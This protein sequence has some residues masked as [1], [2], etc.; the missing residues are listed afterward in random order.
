MN[1]NRPFNAHH[2]PLEAQIEAALRSAPL[3]PPPPLLYAAVMR[4]VR[5]SPPLPRFQ[6]SWLDLA[7]S[8]FLAAVPG[9]IWIG[10]RS[11]PP[12]WF[13]ALRLQTLYQLQRLWYLEFSSMIWV[14]V[15]LGL[16]ILSLAS[17]L[18]GWMIMKMS[19]PERG[20]PAGR[21]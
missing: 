19:F 6:V 16:L 17:V 20:Y 7:L 1:D 5:L 8:L 3:A 15:G 18:G 14:G 12:L 9:L 2:R 11:L 13:E 10:W 21:L 4:R